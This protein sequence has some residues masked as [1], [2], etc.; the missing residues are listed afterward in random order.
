MVFQIADDPR[1]QRLEV[2]VTPAEKQLIQNAAAACGR[3]VSEFIVQRALQRSGF[4]HGE[5]G[6]LLLLHDVLDELEYQTTHRD[7]RSVGQLEMILSG[8]AEILKDVWQSPVVLP[9]PET[10]GE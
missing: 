10:A 6:A 9:L 7:D 4:S 3:S 1:D 2:R 8:L 5:R